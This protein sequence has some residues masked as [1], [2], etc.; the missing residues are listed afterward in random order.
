MTTLLLCS[1]A[2]PRVPNQQGRTPL[3]RAAREVDGIRIELIPKIIHQILHDINMSHDSRIEEHMLTMHILDGDDG[4]VHC[5]HVFF[6]AA[7][8]GHVDIVQYLVDYFAPH[9]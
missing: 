6:Y 2:D 8:M 1:G 3:S 5:Q 4:A 7:I 9:G